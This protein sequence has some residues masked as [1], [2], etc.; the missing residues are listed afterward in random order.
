MKG[1]VIKTKEGLPGERAA[2]RR[3]ILEQRGKFWERGK[4]TRLF[5][6]AKCIVPKKKRVK[7]KDW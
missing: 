7:E 4:G 5:F 2:G 6:L 3:G 1:K